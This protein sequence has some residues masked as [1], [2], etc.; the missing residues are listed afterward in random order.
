MFFELKMNLKDSIRMA[1]QLSS[2]E[3]MNATFSK[4]YKSFC[5]Y[6][7]CQSLKPIPAWLSFEP[8]SGE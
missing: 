1:D 8:P 5:Q 2:F 3:R 7:V 6:D 4:P